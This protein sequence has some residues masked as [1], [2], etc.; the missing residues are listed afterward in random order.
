MVNISWIFGNFHTI[1]SFIESQ[2]IKCIFYLLFIL[3]IVM[4]F[5]MQLSLQR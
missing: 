2:I 3:D 5:T 4:L 1:W